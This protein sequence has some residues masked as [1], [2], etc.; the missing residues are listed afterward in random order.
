[1]SGGHGGTWAKLGLPG[2]LV[3][4]NT[5]IAG[6]EICQELEIGGRSGDPV[7]VLVLWGAIDRSGGGA[8]TGGFAGGIQDGCINEDQVAHFNDTHHDQQQDRYNQ[9]EFN[10][11]LGFPGSI[12]N[13][14]GG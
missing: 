6:G 7:A 9:G 1:M 10:R 4:I 8:I 2:A 5:H 11:A 14:S 12:G 13:T 3:I